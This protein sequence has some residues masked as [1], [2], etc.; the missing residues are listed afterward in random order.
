MH[1]CL[2]IQQKKEAEWLGCFGGLQRKGTKEAKNPT[3]NNPLLLLYLK[4][5]VAPKKKKNVTVK[6]NNKLI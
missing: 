3:Q 6:S 5:Y 4:L 2:D 1:W